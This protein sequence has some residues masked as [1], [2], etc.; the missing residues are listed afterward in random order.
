MGL[1]CLFALLLESPVVQDEL[2]PFRT[3][4]ELSLLMSRDRPSCTK[5]PG[6][7]PSCVMPGTCRSSGCIWLAP[8][9][10]IPAGA[11]LY[12]KES[13]RSVSNPS[14]HFRLPLCSRTVRL[15]MG[16]KG[17]DREQRSVPWMDSGNLWNTACREKSCLLTKV[18]QSKGLLPRVGL[19]GAGGAKTEV[20]SS[21]R[22]LG[23]NN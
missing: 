4:L 8:G 9:W 1:G 5:L 17:S 11:A 10:L 6:N 19:P 16:H 22:S 23:R 13:A 14:P 2:V 15:H 20:L 7:R 3:S 18:S 12:L 21:L